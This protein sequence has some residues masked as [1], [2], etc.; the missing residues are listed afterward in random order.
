MIF[1]SVLFF[2]PFLIFLIPLLAKIK[3]RSNKF[4]IEILALTMG[5]L[6]VSVITTLM[7]LLIVA[8]LIF[9][10]LLIVQSHKG[11]FRSRS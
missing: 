1:F 2:F 3:S 9:V 5:I 8:V 7:P 10:A 6:Y 4:T 11:Y